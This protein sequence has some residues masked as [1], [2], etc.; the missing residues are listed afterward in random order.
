MNG[1]AVVPV[2]GEHPHDQA[3][4]AVIGDPFSGRFEI[5]PDRFN[6]SKHPYGGDDPADP[7]TRTYEGDRTGKNPESGDGRVRSLSENV[8]YDIGYPECNGKSSKD[9]VEERYKIEVPDLGPEPGKCLFVHGCIA[10]SVF[11]CSANKEHETKI[12]MSV[13][14]PE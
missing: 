12:R 13:F 5:V 11:W 2:V 8:S 9:E 6:A 10:L 3:G 1:P 4:D 14:I 7:E